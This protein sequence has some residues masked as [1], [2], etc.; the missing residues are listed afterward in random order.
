MYNN[1]MSKENSDTIEVYEKFG[2][3]YLSRNRSDTANDPKAAQDDAY[4]KE[5]IAK[6]TADLP[7]TAKIFEIGS[8]SGR[9]A[10]TLQQLGFTNVTVSDV[11]DFFIDHLKKEGFAPLKFNLITDEFPDSYDLIFCWAVLVH[12]KKP[13][14]ADAIQKI[15]AALNDSGRFIFSVKH[16]AEHEEEWADY[17]GKIGAKRYFSYWDKDEIE[18][19]L[20]NAGFKNV[21]IVQYGGARACWLQCCAD[22]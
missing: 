22:K 21:E 17:K 8:A 14:V 18:N 2:D 11:A 7:K 9:D 15:Y 19:L 3:N 16:K 13:E 1:H 12:F 5:Y 20:R 6:H 4:Q 10:K